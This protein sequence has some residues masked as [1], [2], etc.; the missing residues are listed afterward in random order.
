MSAFGYS[1][2]DIA[3]ELQISVKTVEAHKSN[4]MRKLRL[5]SRVELVRHALRSGCWSA[6]I[7]P[8]DAR[9]TGAESR[10]AIWQFNVF[11]N[12]TIVPS[13]APS[14]RSV[15]LPPAANLVADAAADTVERI[16]EKRRPSYGAV[17]EAEYDSLTG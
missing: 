12:S 10:S 3:K 9:A 17:V 15:K 4:G 6:T 7:R 5:V 16:T 2:K 1:N 8:T 14:P 13:V 11:A